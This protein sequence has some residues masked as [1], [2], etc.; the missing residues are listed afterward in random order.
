M[1]ATYVSFLLPLRGIDDYEAHLGRRVTYV[2]TISG[3]I[4]FLR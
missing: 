3:V 2:M 1:I 4:S